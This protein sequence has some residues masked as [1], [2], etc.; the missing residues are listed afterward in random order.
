MRWY[1]SREVLDIMVDQG[2]LRD[3]LELPLDLTSGNPAPP[4]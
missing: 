4:W 1:E 3:I 2:R